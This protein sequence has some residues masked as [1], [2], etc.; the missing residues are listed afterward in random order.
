MREFLW[1]EVNK[2]VRSAFYLAKISEAG[3]GIRMH[4]YDGCQ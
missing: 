3:R 1:K 2:R 4:G